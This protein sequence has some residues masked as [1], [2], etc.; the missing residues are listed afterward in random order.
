MLHQ[1]RR[2]WRGEEAEKEGVGES[3]ED[4]EV[5]EARGEGGGEGGGQLK[6]KLTYMD[7][8]LSG[9]VEGLYYNTGLCGV[10]R[11]ES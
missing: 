9:G 6:V 8:V 1:G 10:W 5:G 2:R 11:R 4:D 3:G 7:F